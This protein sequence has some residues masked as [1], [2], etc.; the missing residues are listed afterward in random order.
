MHR[1]FVDIDTK[2]H[3]S[4]S[5]SSPADKAAS[6]DELS[7]LGVSSLRRYTLC[8]MSAWVSSDPTPRHREDFTRAHP[9]EDGQ[10]G[11]ESLP[12]TECSETLL[13]FSHGHRPVIR[14]GSSLRRE[15]Q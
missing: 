6:R 11:N 5:E 12:L 4:I 1:H 15:Q 2:R 9:S 10:L 8:L 13:H 7:V 14:L 3:A